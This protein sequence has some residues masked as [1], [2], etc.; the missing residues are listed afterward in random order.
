MVKVVGAVLIKNGEIFCAQRGND[1]V[2]AGLWEFP[3]GK[4][5]VGET[6]EQA[7]IREM[8]EEFSCR[9][10]VVEKILTVVHEYDFGTVELTTILCQLFEEEP[11]LSEHQAMRWE[12]IEKLRLLDWAPADIPTVEYLMQRFGEFGN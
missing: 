5:E 11:R 4:V 6:E 9:I 7:L 10:A 1:K 12:N 2:L 3:G 8:R